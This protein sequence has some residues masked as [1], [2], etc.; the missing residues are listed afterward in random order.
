LSRR[1][2]EVVGVALFALALLWLVSLVT[3]E[4]SDPVWFFTSGAAH[5]PANFAGRVGA[6][7]AELSFQIAGYAAYLIP[8]IIAVV[9]WHYFWCQTPDAAYTKITGVTLLVAGAAAF[10][11]LAFGSTEVAGKPF[12]AGGSVGEWTGR[13]LS[14]Y[15]NRTGSII[16]LV[17]FMVLAVILSTQ[18]SFGRMFATASANS[19][20]V[21]ARAVGWFRRWL[22][23]RRKIQARKEAVARQVKKSTKAAPATAN[24][25]T[26]EPE[27][28]EPVPARS[29]AGP[30]PVVALRRRTGSRTAPAGAVGPVVEL[31]G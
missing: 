1:L 18:F 19:R 15:L 9:G 10:L 2:S 27:E 14:E 6:F 7:L 8:A 5:P 28:R 11:S 25:S 4:P 24:A 16:V 22:D 12:N 26:S 29:T 13:W 31:D 21:S 3:Y 20:D 17:T 30:A 23:D